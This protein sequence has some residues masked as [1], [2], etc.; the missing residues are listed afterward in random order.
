M[1]NVERLFTMFTDVDVGW[2]AAKALGDVGGSPDVL[3]KKNHAVV[4]VRIVSAV[5]YQSNPPG[6]DPVR[7]TL[8]QRCLAPH[9]HWREVCSWWV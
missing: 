7:A 2:D 3:I 6:S 4:R 5:F 1:V 8:L 9:S